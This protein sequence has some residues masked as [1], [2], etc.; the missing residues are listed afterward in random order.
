MKSLIS[1]MQTALAMLVIYAVTL[2]S[3]GCDLKITPDKLKEWN[4]QSENIGLL[5]RQASNIAFG[6]WEAG[7]ITLETKNDIFDVFLRLD[8][9]GIA[10]H[11]FVKRKLAEH[12]EGKVSKSV[13]AEIV[14]VF[15]SE[16]LEKF[17]NALEKLKVLKVSAK[18]RQTISG[19]KTA[20]LVF[21]DA[22]KIGSKTRKEIELKEMQLAYV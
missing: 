10:F 6:L 5:S 2:I 12:G 21:A 9:G 19:I 13:L 1:K 17:L 15:R 22:L 3:A 11:N 8:E 4:R 20:V 16:L 14:E 18:L 7:E